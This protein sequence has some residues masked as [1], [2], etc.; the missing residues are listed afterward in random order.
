[1]DDDWGSV[2]LEVRDFRKAR[3]F[4]LDNVAVDVFLPKIGATAFAVYAYLCRFVFNETQVCWPT[5]A[6]M[7]DAL[8]LSKGTI[9]KNLKKLADS[10]MLRVVEQGKQHRASRYQLLDIVSQSFPTETLN[11][12]RV[13][14]GASSVSSEAIQSFPTVPEQH[15]V[16]N[17][18][19][20]DLFCPPSS[21]ALSEP[22]SKPK[23][24]IKKAD[25]DPRYPEFIEAL[26]TGYKRRGWEFLFNGADGKQLKALLE[27]RK[28]MKVQEFRICLKHYFDSDGIIPGAMPHT[29]LMKLPNYW[30]GPLNQFGK[31]MEH[32]TAKHEVLEV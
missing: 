18:K 28:T 1:M 21:D 9:S 14:R 6:Q 25:S 7:A 3:F 29:Y 24:K 13:S 23:S 32:K 31:L 4:W 10:N 5:T 30:A 12:S 15:L 26:S 8:Q 22:K 19:E 16:N 11:T 2:T 20:Q 27:Y 17:T